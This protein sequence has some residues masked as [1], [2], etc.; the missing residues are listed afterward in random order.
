VKVLF[1]HPANAVNGARELFDH[2]GDTMA[3]VPW[4]WYRR[5]EPLGGMLSLATHMTSLASREQQY[6]LIMS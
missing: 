3:D 4:Q 2:T 1:G 6:K 5:E